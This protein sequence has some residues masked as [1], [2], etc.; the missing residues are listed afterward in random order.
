MTEEQQGGTKPPAE[1]TAEAPATEQTV[2]TVAVADEPATS[3]SLDDRGDG[4]RAPD[5]RGSQPEAP[6]RAEAPAAEAAVAGGRAARGRD[7]GRRAR[8]SRRPEPA[9]AAAE[10]AAAVRR[11]ADAAA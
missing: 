2:G 1:A 11:R 8:A 6:R 5:R 7:R 10:A 3:P 9:A 4:H